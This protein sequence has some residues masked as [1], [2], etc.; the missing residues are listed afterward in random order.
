MKTGPTPAG[1]IRKL[2]PS[3]GIVLMA[4]WSKVETNK[5]AGNASQTD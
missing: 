3:L 2:D 4:P 1:R 5:Q